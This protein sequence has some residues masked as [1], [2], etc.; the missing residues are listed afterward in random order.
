MA[1]QTS[2]HVFQRTT[3]KKV[4]GVSLLLIRL[5]QK[6]KHHQLEGLISS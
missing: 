5:D 6:D 1:Q 3:L 2:N 4:H